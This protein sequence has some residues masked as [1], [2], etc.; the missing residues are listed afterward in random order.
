MDDHPDIRNLRD[1]VPV[2]FHQVHPARDRL[3]TKIGHA[4]D[5]SILL[6]AAA[7]LPCIIALWRWA[8]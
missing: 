6:V 2:D 3:Y 1:R 7:A 8:L 5:W 4:I